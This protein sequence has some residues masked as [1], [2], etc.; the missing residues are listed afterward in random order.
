VSVRAMLARVQRLEQGRSPTSPF[1]RWFG[2]LDVFTDDLR[3]GV[4]AGV[5]DATDMPVVIA[6]V[7]RWHRDCL[8]KW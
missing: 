3:A 4:A 2:A 8:W 5:Y 1:E 6:S 7:E